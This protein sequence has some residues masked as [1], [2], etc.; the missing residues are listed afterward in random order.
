MITTVRDGEQTIADAG[1]SVIA[2]TFSEWEWIVVDD[3]SDDQSVS[4]VNEFVRRDKRVRQISMPKVGRGR[5]LNRGVEEAAGKFIAILDAD[6]LFHPEKLEIQH[7]VITRSESCDVVATRDM[8]VGLGADVVWDRVSRER[9]NVCE[10]GMEIWRCNPI[11]H[12]SV[13]MR[14]SAIEEVGGYDEN[15][16]SQ[17]DYDLWVRMREAEM[18][19]YLIGERLVAKR[20]HR[21]QCFERQRRVRYLLESAK[22]QLRACSCERRILLGVWVV[23][24]R[25]LW[26]L[27]PVQVRVRGRRRLF[28]A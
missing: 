11:C 2:Q 8:L 1:F 6:D 19:M 27:L 14:R 17:Y 20:I 22:V 4:I 24:A 23:A 25:F 16:S 9:V 26:G 10:V 15:R 7:S 13:L 28:G 12:S 3:G 5:A 21:K 18:K